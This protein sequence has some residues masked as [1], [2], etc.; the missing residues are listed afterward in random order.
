[1]KVFHAGTSLVEDRPMTDGGRVLGVTA[2]GD[3]LAMAKE[4]AYAAADQI[5]F[6]GKVCRRDIGD[7]GIAAERPAG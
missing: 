3:T 1:V 6:P 5:V 4:R 7:K 2:L